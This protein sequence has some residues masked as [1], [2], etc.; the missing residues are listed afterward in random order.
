MLVCGTYSGLQRHLPSWNHSLTIRMGGTSSLAGRHLPF[1]RA[2]A[3]RGPSRAFCRLRG[4]LTRHVGRSTGEPHRL[5]NAAF[6]S[7]WRP[8]RRCGPVQAPPTGRSEGENV[9]DVLL[10]VSTWV[11]L[12]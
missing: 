2:G 11:G 12:A 1:V 4:N 7:V 6:T 8:D 9:Q 10:A 3:T 5:P